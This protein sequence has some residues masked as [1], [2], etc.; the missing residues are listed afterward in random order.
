MDNN[1]LLDLVRLLGRNVQ[2]EYLTNMLY[3]TVDSKKPQIN[4]SELLFDEFKQLATDGTDL[5]KLKQRIDIKKEMYLSRDL[6]LPWPWKR[7]RLCNGMVSIGKGR[8][9]GVWKEDETNHFI[10][11][12]LPM[13]IGWVKNG[14]HSIAVGIIQGEGKIEVN[15]VYDISSVYDYV[16]CDGIKYYRKEDGCIISSVKNM[17]FAAI[18]EIGRLLKENRICF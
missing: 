3:I 6:I 10:E 12:W 11:L 2:A 16:Y 17:D 8:A 14:N 15:E 9:N 4:S 7:G 13:G 18:F 5:R 1:P